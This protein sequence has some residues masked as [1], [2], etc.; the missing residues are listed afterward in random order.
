MALKTQKTKWGNQSINYWFVS[1]FSCNCGMCLWR[2][3][4][5]DLLTRSSEEEE[6]MAGGK[7][8]NQIKISLS[9]YLLRCDFFNVVLLLSFS[10]TLSG[11]I[12]ISNQ[13]IR[14]PFWRFCWVQCSFCS[15]C[16]FC[17]PSLCLS[18]LW[19]KQ[20]KVLSFSLSVFPLQSLSLSPICSQVKKQRLKEK[21]VLLWNKSM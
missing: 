5:S 12:T 8:R 20:K 1:Y 17:F 4:N 7:M 6:V 18:W 16:S 3:W 2:N 9:T 11:T 15:F 19:H 14:F 13:W 21:S 10:V